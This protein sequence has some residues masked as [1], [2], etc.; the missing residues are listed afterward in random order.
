MDTMGRCAQR[1]SIQPRSDDKTSFSPFHS[2]RAPDSSEDE[3]DT[4]YC[5]GKMLI[6]DKQAPTWM[7][8]AQSE[9]GSLAF[10]YFYVV[11]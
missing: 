5:M 3:G 1:H 4:L 8:C 9:Q 2:I 7:H 6:C 11:K 10:L